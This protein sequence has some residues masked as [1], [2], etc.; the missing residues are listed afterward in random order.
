MAHSPRE[1]TMATTLE[2]QTRLEALGFEPG[3]LDGKN[4]A[5]TIKAV[6]AFGSIPLM[7]GADYGTGPG[8]VR[9]TR[10][11]RRF[12]GSFSAYRLAISVR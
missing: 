1:V 3:P 10:W 2:I 4:G 5:N 7:C 12:G 6:K 8:G 9:M 11:S